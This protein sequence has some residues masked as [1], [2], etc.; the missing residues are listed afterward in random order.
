MAWVFQRRK[1]SFLH[2]KATGIRAL[3]AARAL[4]M[5]SKHCVK[6]ESSCRLPLIYDHHSSMMAILMLDAFHGD[7]NPM[8]EFATYF[9]TGFA[10]PQ[11][12]TDGAHMDKIRLWS[13]LANLSQRQSPWNSQRKVEGT[14]MPRTNLGPCYTSGYS[15]SSVFAFVSQS[16][17]ANEP[18]DGL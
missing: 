15:N 6:P 4:A 10:V 7:G 8:D 12:S 16:A 9:T 13:V 3:D 5:L 17:G 11:I 1:P 18:P 2:Q 14:Y